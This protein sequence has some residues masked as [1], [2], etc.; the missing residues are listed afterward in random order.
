MHDPQPVSRGERIGD[1][2][3]DSQSLLDRQAQSL[4]AGAGAPSLKCLAVEQLH[5]EK[6]RVRLLADVIQSADIRMG[7]SRNRSRLTVET[8]P[9]LRIAGQAFGEDFDRDG[10]IEP[11]VPALVHLAHPTFANLDDDFVNAEAGAG[12]KGQDRCRL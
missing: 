5:H 9:E 6:S 3:R 7:E 8:L 2:D 10:A 4:G 11:R 1:L 12:R